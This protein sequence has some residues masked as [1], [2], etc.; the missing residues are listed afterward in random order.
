MG[1]CWCFR[2]AHPDRRTWLG[3][4]HEHAP[5]HW[6]LGSHRI[7]AHHDC[8]LA[9]IGSGR[10]PAGL[11]YDGVPPSLK[12]VD[13]DKALTY[14]RTNTVRMRYAQNRKLGMFVGSSSGSGSGSVEVGAK[15]SSANVSNSPACTGP[16]PAPP[17]SSPCAPSKRAAPGTT[18]GPTPTLRPQPPT[19]PS[20]EPDHGHLQIRLALRS[21]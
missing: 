11:Y 5:S 10:R 21:S 12:A 4:P 14:F 18:S 19:S 15:P 20:A 8:R 3:Q 17:A 16:T 6:L 2:L 1:R 7:S 13:R 9:P